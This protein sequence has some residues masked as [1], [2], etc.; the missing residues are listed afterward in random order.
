LSTPAPLPFIDLQAQRR[1]LGGRIEAAIA[2]V[3][4]HGQFIMG[5]EVGAFEAALA[6]YLGVRHAI[7]CASGTDALILPLRARGI[8]PGDAVFVPAFT[9]AATAE[10]PALLGATPVLVDVEADTCNLDPASLAAAVEMV[11]A[12][13][14]LTPRAVIPVDLYGQPADY[15]AIGGLCRAAG[16]FVVQDAA[17]SFGARVDGAP[18]GAQ[19]DVG[20]TSFYPSKPLGGYGDGGAMFTDDDGLAEMLRSLRAH[21]AGPGGAYD[22]QRLGVTGRLDTLQAAILIEKLALL[23][24]ELE[25]RSAVAARYQAG[26]GDVVEV[27]R[28]RPGL[29]SA[30][31]QY[32]IM[33]AGRERLRADLAAA[34]IPTAV[35]YPRPLHRQPA[36]AGCP[37]APGGL[38]VAEALAGTVVSLPMHPYLGEADQARVVAAVRAALVR[39]RG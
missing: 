10:A 7:S 14:E 11:A 24:D 15:A 3:L 8:G 1:R 31:A 35:H 17:Q 4:D 18:A 5:P 30:W 20:A 34:G 2:R 39:A 23:D 27:P 32:T 12:K 21:G 26:L 22:H 29:R 19:G 38:P 33:V 36:Y 13:G 37:V 9:F 6:S 28:I 16:L 25:A